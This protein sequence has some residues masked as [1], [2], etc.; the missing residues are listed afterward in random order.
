MRTLAS[1]IIALTL[2]VV[3]GW[4]WSALGGAA[5][6]WLTPNGGWWRGAIAVGSAWAA[7]IAYNLV[8]AFEPVME[9][10]RVVG[11]I[12]GG[13]PSWTIPLASVLVGSVI[14]AAGGFFGSSLRRLKRQTAPESTQN[15]K[16]VQYDS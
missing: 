14:G 4:P 5:A 16:S 9:M 10:H 13:L 1:S 2:H 15:D 3:A 8:A 7:L 12:A 6:G 11:S